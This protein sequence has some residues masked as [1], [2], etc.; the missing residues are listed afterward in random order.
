MEQPELADIVLQLRKRI[1]T[2][3][4]KAE[5]MERSIDFLKSVGPDCS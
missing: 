2:L 1:E 3:E 4:E 5:K